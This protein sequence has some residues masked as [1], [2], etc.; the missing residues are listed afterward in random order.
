MLIALRVL[1]IE[2]YE[3][4]AE[5][6]LRQL[7]K[8]GYEAQAERVETLDALQTALK[9]HEWDLVISDYRLPT[10]DA[11][12][13]IDLLRK[14]E[15][16]VPFIVVSGTIGEETAAALMRSGAHDYLVK[17][18]LARLGAVVDRELL[19]ARRRAGYRRAEQL[20]HESELRYRMLF[21]NSPISLC[22]MDFSRVKM[23]LDQLVSNGVVDFL[24]YFRENPGAA[25]EVAGLARVL[26]VNQT[27]LTLYHADNKQELLAYLT[28]VVQ[29]DPLGSARNEL[30][31][32]ASGRHTFNYETV[33]RTVD[34]DL[35]DVSLH[36]AVVSGHEH[37]L[38]RVIISV[39][40]ISPRKN[41]ERR[42]QQAEA[43]Q[44]RW[45]EMMPACVYT[46][47]IGGLGQI[48][49]ISPQIEAFTGYTPDSWY[50]RENFWNVIIHPDDRS[51]VMA[52]DDK[53]ELS[54]ESFL[55]EYRVIT[56]D[57][58][59]VW[60][61]DDAVLLRDEGG[62][63]MFWLGVIQDV[64]L[65]K[66]AEF[67]MKESQRR[68]AQ[69]MSSLPGMAYRT[70]PGSN[71]ALEFASEGCLQLTGYSSEE[72]TA[73][74]GMLLTRMIHPEDLDNE[75]DIII[76]HLETQTPFQVSYRIFTP[77][78][79]QKWV[80]E[81]G[82]G[83]FNALGE[84]T[85][86][87]GFIA[88]ISELKQAEAAIRRHLSEQEVLYQ[89]SLVINRLMEPRQIAGKV[90]DILGEKMNW[91]H[92]SVRLF[93]VETQRLELLAAD[94]EH[95]EEQTVVTHGGQDHRPEALSL[96]VFEHGVPAL[97]PNVREDTRYEEIH[98]EV[99]SG[100]Y[101]PLR[102]GERIIGTISLES[103][104][105][106]AFTERDERLLSTIANQ[107]AISIENSQL[108]LLAQ[109]ELVARKD[110]ETQLLQVQSRLE[111]RV[112]ER[113][114]DLKEANQALEKAARMKD[115]FMA[116]MSHELRTPLTGILGLTDVLQMQTYGS[117]SVKQLTALQHIANSGRHLLELI[118]D[119][120]DLARIEARQLVLR[121]GI[122]RLEQICQSCLRQVAEPAS[123][124][125]LEISLQMS[126]QNINVQADAQR[127]KQV[128]NNLLSNAL[129]FTPEGGKI[130][131]DVRGDLENHEVHITVW[132]TGIGIR[133]EDMSRLFQNFVQLDSS[134]GRQYNGTGLGLV[135]VKRLTELQG[136]RIDVE[137]RYGEGSRF[138][139]SLPW[140]G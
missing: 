79:E 90:V 70:R 78:G 62:S 35:I 138:T 1:I 59:V 30:L 108:F 52:L 26:D 2:D 19:E 133:A 101:V 94:G 16:D 109:V 32:I 61:R 4:D 140:D 84:I 83:I 76:T 10:F 9:E 50:N 107:A 56:R 54:G 74:E 95:N 98:P 120:L 106:N 49:Y 81:Q 3:S 136:G 27:A 43:R 67:E 46:E 97:C 72:L 100:V 34:G 139:I 15:L 24:A 18:N 13:V 36:W 28:G 91:H 73:G 92:I 104:L 116:S 130:G 8:A 134:L 41:V 96:W 23:R 12:A 37:D 17:D 71:W 68:L 45:I 89:N 123:Q 121:L 82:Q 31:M 20:V 53:T 117:L 86:V 112:A 110:A 135:L 33:Q 22:E 40:D 85:A 55:A 47:A 25:Q 60:L 38:E 93:N 111:Q 69:L 57:E 127:L 118:N 64:S 102:T 125:K 21:E 126:P 5:L 114:A 80:W 113:T 58:R 42:L 66:K 63:P 44:R 11:P 14:S 99:R 29:D 48:T 7:E 103:N 6:I 88:D 122:C 129:K 65:P 128:L 131:V 75:H 105:E 87:E 124:K 77:R 137:S 119:I 132:D 39:Q 51:F 115:E